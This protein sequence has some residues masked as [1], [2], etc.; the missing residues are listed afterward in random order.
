M[1]H[2]SDTAN[3]TH[4]SKGNVNVPFHTKHSSVKPPKPEYRDP[5]SQIAKQ[6]RDEN[7]SKKRKREQ[8]ESSRKPNGLRS[9]ELESINTE[10]LE[11]GKR[12]KSKKPKKS[13]LVV[14]QDEES[15]DPDERARMKKHGEIFLKYQMSAQLAEA[16]KK[17]TQAPT[18][19]EESVPPVAAPELHGKFKTLESLRR[20]ELRIIDLIPI[21]QP[22]PVPESEYKPTFLALPSWLAKPVVVE[23]NFTASFAELNL[24]SKL[25]E[26]LHRKGYEK[27]LAVQAAVIPLL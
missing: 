23:S 10:R 18:E 9:G 6:S 1:A 19:Q 24:D 13:K 8:F 25:V 5:F 21:P 3:D 14:S 7:K 17:S 2:A 16:E 20:Y 11:D 4:N 22:S 26:N 15:I 12:K 27:S